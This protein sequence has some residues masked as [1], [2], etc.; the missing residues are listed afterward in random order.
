MRLAS[1]R[2]KKIFGYLRSRALPCYVSQVLPS[3]AFPLQQSWLGYNQHRATVFSRDW[4]GILSL[5]ELI[6][7]LRFS[8]FRFCRQ[9][10]LVSVVRWIHS[11][12]PLSPI[13]SEAV[14]LMAV[15]WHCARGVV[16]DQLQQQFGLHLTVWREEAEVFCMIFF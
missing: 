1:P 13:D 12:Y 2:F 11:G 10:C 15:E 4:P 3:A 8:A 14:G 6:Q 16:G 7:A 9:T 5:F